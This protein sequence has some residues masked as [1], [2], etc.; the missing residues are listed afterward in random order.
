MRRQKRE[1]GG[2]PEGENKGSP[3][4]TT[5]SAREETLAKR[6]GGDL[7]LVQDLIFKLVD[8]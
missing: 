1:S 8:R 6:K 5:L 4:S 7:Y 2:G 3:P